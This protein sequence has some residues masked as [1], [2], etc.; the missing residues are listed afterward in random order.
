MDRFLIAL[1][2]QMHHAE[3]TAG[4]DIAALEI[5]ERARAR[6]L[7]DSLSET[8]AQI[9]EGVDVSLRERERL[10]R[11][12]LSLHSDRLTRLLGG[13]NT[14][15][16]VQTLRKQVET[17]L[18]EYRD[19]ET[20]IRVKNPRYTALTQPQ[21][22]PAKAIQKLLDQDTLLLEYAL[23][24]ERSFVWAITADSIKSFDLP[25]R[26]AIET[27]ADRFIRVISENQNRNVPQQIAAADELSRLVLT[28]VAKQFG[29]KKIVIVADGALLR[30]PFSALSIAASEQPTNARRKAAASAYQP[31]VLKHEIVHLPSASV[32]A[33]VRR[34]MAS[35]SAPDKSVAVIAD[36]VFQSGD[37]RVKTNVSSLTNQK[38][39]SERERSAWESGL[40]NLQRLPYSRREADAIVS[41]VANDQSFKAVDFAANRAAVSHDVLAHYRVVHFATHA[42][43][44]NSY[45]ELSGVVLSL[46]DENGAPQN[47]FLRLYEIYNLRLSSDLVVLSACRTA[48]GKQVRGE[49]LIGL[50]RGFMYAGSPRV[51]VSLWEVN[52]E[53]TAELMKKFYT[54]MFVHQMRPAAALRN[55]QAA[56]LRHR[57]WNAPYYWAAFEIQGEFR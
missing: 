12:Q 4:H 40:E 18:Q 8:Y 38:P 39:P 48:L 7:L 11:Q 31:L 19:V 35:H 15:A 25:G 43:L 16:Q 44:N 21:L 10:V 50:T 45:P 26:A 6:T 57:W 47:G 9:N 33:V 46:V 52:D 28:P 23:G 17:L 13:K 36:P 53:A 55:A 1:L 34:E 3:P 41:L 56:M 24:S 20:Q 14:E 2:M 22:L 29:Q 30:V 32:L 27:A 54:A 42:L 37:P 5:S 51:M 49:G